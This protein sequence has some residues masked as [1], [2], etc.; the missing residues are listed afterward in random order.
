MSHEG[1]EVCAGT[2]F[3]GCISH[4]RNH[5]RKV[6]QA[7]VAS[8]YGLTKG[9]DT[10]VV[11]LLKKN[12]FI[13]PVNSKD[14]LIHSKPYKAPVILDTIGDAFFGDDTS[15]GTKFHEK[16]VSTVEDRLDEQEL[17]VAM[18]ALAG[19]AVCSIIMQYWSKKYNCDLNCE[20][21]SGI[22]KTLVGILNG[23]FEMSERKYH[24]LMHSIYKTVY[25][26]KVNMVCDLETDEALMFL[27]I[28]AMP[29]SGEE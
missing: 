8:H 19:T 23:I 10:K 11:D 9:A 13:Y 17:P 28:D 20:L 6:A 4:F 15:M 12:M 18:V 27:D 16:F 7:H 22:Y 14:E 24:V 25:G 1:F 3:S 2:G 29:D 26:L 21:Y 5:V